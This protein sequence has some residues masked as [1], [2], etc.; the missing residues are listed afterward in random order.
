MEKKQMEP[1]MKSPVFTL[2]GVLDALQALS[3]AASD[4]GLPRSTVELVGMR[5]SQINGCAPCLD[6]HGRAAK[7][8]GETD[9]RLLTLAAW[10]ES[11]Y[12]DD[13]ERAALALTEAG[14]R[15]ADRADQV[16][17]EVL[18]EAG[19]HFDERALA[20]L[21]VAIAAINTWNRLN[22]ITGQVAG[23]WTAQLVG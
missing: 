5:A 19:R 6:I 17:D 1:R 12:F 22:V 7:K 23:E 2:T 21:V 18:A 9:E 13:A 16:P 15:L 20:A 8:A 14:T 4:T 10:R 3:E 11:P